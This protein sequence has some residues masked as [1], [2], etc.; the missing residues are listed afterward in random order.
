MHRSLR[1]GPGHFIKDGKPHFVVSGEIHYFRLDVRLWEKHLR[2]LKA[3]GANTT[4]TYIPWDWH[5]PSP[6]ETD[7]TGLTHPGRNLIRYMELCAKVG[8]D[9]IV[10]PGPYILAEYEVHGLPPWFLERCGRGARAQ[11][12]HGNVIAP[13]L[14]CY[15]S[16]EFLRNAFAWYDQVMPLLSMFQEKNGGPIT[17]MQICNEVGIFQWLS[18][19]IDYNPAVTDLYRA[20]LE[21][22]YGEISRVNAQYGT[23][24]GDFG[25]ALPP[26]GMIENR[27]DYRAYYDFHLFYRHYFALYLDILAKRVRSY[28]IETQ[29]THNIPGWIFGNAAELP[30][31]IST[32][33]EVMRTRKDIV[34]G[35]DHIPEFFSYRNAHSDLACNKIL[36]A[37]QPYGPVWAAEYQA[38][39]R[40]HFVRNDPGDMDAFYAASLA[41]G[42]NGFNYYMFSGGVNPEGR[43]YY[44]KSFYYQTPLDPG[45]K[46]TPLYAV[47][48]KNAAFIRREG[49]NLLASRARARVCVGLYKPYFYTEL[50]TSQ[51]LREK[52]LHAE[53]I[54]LAFDPRFVREELFFNGILRGLQTLNFNYD[55]SDL[56][57]AP[58][59]DL[60]RYRQLWVVAAE[61]MDAPTQERLAAYVAGGGHLIVTPVVPTLDEY[62]RPCTIL[63]DA[64][65]LRFTGSPACGK[66]K[67]FGIDEI[68]SPVGYRQIFDATAATAVATTPEGA[69][70]GVSAASGKGRV[71][72]LGFAFGY[73]TDDHLIL[74][75][76]IVARDRITRDA[77]VSDPDIQFVLRRGKKRSY[78]FLMNYHNR[79]TSFTVD[80]RRHSLGPF[81]CTIVTKKS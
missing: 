75:E 19:R 69:V 58:V 16:E 60:L 28:G 77:R 35:L 56:E 2:A 62:L 13:E 5:A 43:G 78:L 52:R 70:C 22:R 67:A 12:E 55:I 40:E 23:T 46:P 74:L 31:L 39:T 29:L 41:H 33:E 14:M 10:K 24:W 9:L 17:M 63:R 3:A 38:G 27:N 54:G 72:A 49:E 68:Y 21:E 79:K 45:G 37:M 65:G 42:L 34:F 18:G 8:L 71:T 32:Y 57:I 44:G 36:A 47:A 66:V 25:A 1:A 11:D 80:G 53:K 81:S 30:M 61:F 76:K 59:R 50:T 51:M 26:R 7:F 4:S 64:L 20:W 15:M 6:E 73:T 48:K